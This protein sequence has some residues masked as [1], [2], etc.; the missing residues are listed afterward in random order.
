MIRQYKQVVQ[1]CDMKAIVYAERGSRILEQPIVGTGAETKVRP[2]PIHHNS[3]T[4]KN[5]TGRFGFLC[6]LASNINAGH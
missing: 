3:N 4:L 2:C 5:T 1:T 6:P